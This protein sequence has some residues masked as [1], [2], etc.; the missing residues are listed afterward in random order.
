MKKATRSEKQGSLPHKGCEQ[1][2]FD[3]KPKQE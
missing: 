2:P 3:S 1:W